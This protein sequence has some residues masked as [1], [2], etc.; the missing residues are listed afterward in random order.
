[1]FMYC[2]DAMLFYCH[3]FVRE[4][5]LPLVSIAILCRRE[6]RHKAVVYPRVPDICDNICFDPRRNVFRGNVRERV[7]ILDRLILPVVY[8]FLVA[9]VASHSHCSSALLNQ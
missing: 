6:R 1:M 3:L 8:L 7:V 2:C 4:N 5:H 9:Y